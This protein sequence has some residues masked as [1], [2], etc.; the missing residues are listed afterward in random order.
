GGSEAEWDALI[1]RA[2]RD[3]ISEQLVEIMWLRGKCALRQ[4]S[5]AAATRA[6]AAA[7]AEARRLSSALSGPIEPDL[8]GAQT[9]HHR[10]PTRTLVRAASAVAP[11]QPLEAHGKVPS[12]M[13]ANPL[14]ETHLLA[15]SRVYS[16]RR[17]RIQVTDGPERGTEKV[18]DATEFG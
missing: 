18:S 13:G 16:F 5:P 15:R 17:F 8:A 12:D 10:T 7:L 6:L 2:R 1:E 3:A 14:A 9:M 11:P 4:H